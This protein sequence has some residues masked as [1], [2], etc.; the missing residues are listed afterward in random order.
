MNFNL[1]EVFSTLC[2]KF[3]DA[4]PE[5]LQSAVQQAMNIFDAYGAGN[6]AEYYNN[7][8]R[9]T[10]V[11]DER[12]K[13]LQAMLSAG[14][15]SADDVSSMLGDLG[16]DIDY[17]NDDSILDSYANHLFNYLYTYKP[18]AQNVD[19]SIDPSQE[20]IGIMAQDLEKVN[21]S[22]VKET[23]DGVK[24]VDTGRLALMNSG[25]I[26]DLARELISMKRRLKAAGV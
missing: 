12:C 26:A 2:K 22:C 7:A 9:S 6:G 1:A 25:A 20:Q 13:Q 4:S 17:E 10:T 19:P 21:P 5:L 14:N 11:S 18:E 16:I 3:K 15:V 8:M 24:T 23:P